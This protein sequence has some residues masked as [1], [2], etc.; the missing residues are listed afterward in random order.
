MSK[1]KVIE[2]KEAELRGAMK[3]LDIL[4]NNSYYSMGKKASSRVKVELVYYLGQ[5]WAEKLDT[6]VS[7]INLLTLKEIE[8]LKQKFN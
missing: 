6:V 7:D 5:D 8:S 2:V 4:W 1:L 3:M